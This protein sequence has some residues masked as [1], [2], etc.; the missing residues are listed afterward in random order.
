VRAAEGAGGAR[1]G[2]L[3]ARAGGARDLPAPAYLP[4]AG[5][6][7]KQAGAR[8]T[9]GPEAH[10]TPERP[11]QRRVPGAADGY[12]KPNWGSAFPGGRRSQGTCSGFPVPGS[13]LRVTG[14]TVQLL[15]FAKV[16]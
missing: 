15:R 1:V 9:R 16:M 5:R 10:A 11:W 7:G 12:R 13:G 8:M 14:N 3:A 2:R 4:E 6:A